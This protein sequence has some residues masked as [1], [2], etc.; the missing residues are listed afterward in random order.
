L[1]PPEPPAA[2]HARYR[3]LTTSQLDT[4]RRRLPEVAADRLADLMGQLDAL[5][6]VTAASLRAMAGSVDLRNTLTPFG[7][8]FLAYVLAD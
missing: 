4:L 3:S 5:D 7:Q 6:I 1:Q 2:E 8:R